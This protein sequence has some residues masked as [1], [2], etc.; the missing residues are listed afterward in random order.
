LARALACPPPTGDEELQIYLS[1]TA[2]FFVFFIPQLGVP[3]T[4]INGGRIVCL[5]FSFLKRDVEETE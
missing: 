1:F 4:L 3:K 2:I 5:L